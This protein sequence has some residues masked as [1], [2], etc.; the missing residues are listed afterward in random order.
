MADRI[1]TKY[2]IITKVGDT[3]MSATTIPDQI[4]RRLLDAID[5]NTLEDGTLRPTPLIK[6]TF[7]Q[8]VVSSKSQKSAKGVLNAAL[9]LEMET[10]RD[11]CQFSVSE[12][13]ELF[14]DNFGSTRVHNTHAI[15][16]IRLYT[17]FC[18]SLGVRTSNDIGVFSPNVV[19]KIRESMVASPLHLS[20]KLDRAFSAVE[21]NSSEIIYRCILWLAFAGVPFE[22]L[23]QITVDDVNLSGLRVVSCGSAYPLYP[24]GIPAFE[25]AKHNLSFATQTRGGHWNNSLRTPGNLL[26]RGIKKSSVNATSLMCKLNLNARKHDISFGYM[27]I[28][29][30]GHFYRIYELERIG[31]TPDFSVAL[32]PNIDGRS[33]IQ[34]KHYLRV[35]AALLAKDYELWKEAFR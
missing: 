33:E 16:V 17:E 15:Y 13:N 35:S 30:S 32:S 28:K 21:T 29:K 19:D 10:G 18:A 6:E 22:E 27:M 9:K 2:C 5:Q 4:S 20:I 34:Y 12:Y 24:E 31:Y 1:K 14:S 23:S 3:D 25:R 8:Y 7:V 11:L 26:L